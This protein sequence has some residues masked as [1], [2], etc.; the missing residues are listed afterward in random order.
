MCR[1]GLV[2]DNRYAW[3]TRWN[4]TGYIVEVR[5]YLDSA[6]VAAAIVGNE[7]AEFKYSD[8]RDVILPSTTLSEEVLM[9]ATG[10]DK[11]CD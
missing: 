7:I 1:K 10:L 11:T 4:A 5:A 6:L 3:V 2:F 9:G 8:A